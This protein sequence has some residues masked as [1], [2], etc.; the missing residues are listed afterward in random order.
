MAD[1][2]RGRTAAAASAAAAAAGSGPKKETSNGAAAKTNG[3]STSTTTT[4]TTLQTALHDHQALESLNEKDYHNAYIQFTDL[5]ERSTKDDHRQR[6]YYFIGRAC[7]L[8]G[9][10]QFEY[11]E[12]D[13]R[14]AIELDGN[15]PDA[16]TTLGRI[17]FHRRQLDDAASCCQRSFDI[18]NNPRRNAAAYRWRAH[19]AWTKGDHRLAMYMLCSLGNTNPDVQNTKGQVL[20]EMNRPSEAIRALD[21][22]I[23]SPTATTDQKV[24]LYFTRGIAM[25]RLQQLGEAVNMFTHALSLSTQSL[26]LRSQILVEQGSVQYRLGRRAD[27]LNSFE[28]ALKEN[29]D[30]VLALHNLAALLFEDRHTYET[31]SVDDTLARAVRLVRQAIK[32]APR[33]TGSRVLYA[34]ILLTQ[35]DCE[36][37]IDECNTVLNEHASYYAA[38]CHKAEAQFRLGRGQDALATYAALLREF[39]DDAYALKRYEAINFAYPH[40]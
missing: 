8:D 17:L 5:I 13:A 29:P 3:H 30:S 36:Q 20:C 18:D 39:P 23:Q 4:H 24:E 31:T 14:S 12:R 7:A 26:S 2:D 33:D 1:S 27:A 11:A 16:H 38:F 22:G 32:K 34:E 6:V 40:E 21:V 37:A 35:G 10:E 9:L 19:I 28:Q 25:E 15:I